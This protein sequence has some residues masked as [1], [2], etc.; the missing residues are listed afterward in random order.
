MFAKR[1]KE[2]NELTV[3][4]TLIKKMEAKG[5]DPEYLPRNIEL[6]GKIIL[7][8]QDFKNDMMA[9]IGKS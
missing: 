8:L 1:K 7:I 6:I 5:D 4:T 2:I 9:R 3:L